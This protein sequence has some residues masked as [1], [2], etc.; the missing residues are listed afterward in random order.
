MK[1]PPEIIFL[2]YDTSAQRWR[3]LFKGEISTTED[4]D[5]IIE[6]L[7]NIKEE[8]IQKEG[9]CVVPYNPVRYEQDGNNF[10]LV[11]F[12]V[13]YRVQDEDDVMTRFLNKFA[14]ELQKSFFDE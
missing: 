6:I 2:G 8:F 11:D 13:D 3:T 10:I 5:P 9:A 1:T 14:K 12:I 4:K 7:L